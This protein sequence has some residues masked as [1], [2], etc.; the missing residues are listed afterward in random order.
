MTEYTWD[1]HD[2]R[3][4]IKCKSNQFVT[5]MMVC[6]G[7]D[8][9]MPQTPVEAKLALVTVLNRAMLPVVP[10]VTNPV[11]VAPL[12]SITIWFAAVDAGRCPDGKLVPKKNWIAIPLVH[13]N[14]GIVTNTAEPICRIFSVCELEVQGPVHVAVKVEA[15]VT[16]AHD[17][18][19]V[20]LDVSTKPVVGVVVS[21]NAGVTR[22]LTV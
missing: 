2:S 5:I 7:V 11:L 1:R 20:E 18:T 19:P 8:A 16:E 15:A 21:L 13:V 12:F 3:Q 14:V 4:I 10:I 9:G 22:P 6:W 17:P